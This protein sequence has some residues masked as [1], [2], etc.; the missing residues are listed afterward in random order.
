MTDNRVPFDNNWAERNIRAPKLKYKH[1]VASV[2]PKVLIRSA[3]STIYYLLSTAI[4]PLYANSS[5][6]YSRRLCSHSLE[7]CFNLACG[8]NS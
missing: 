1:L 2:R 4:C 7:I 3:L 8:L 6:L 5:S